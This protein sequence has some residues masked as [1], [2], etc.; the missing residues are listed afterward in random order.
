VGGN[1]AAAN[2]L[3][4][5]EKGLQM[6]LHQ[7]LVYPVAN[8]GFDTPSYQENAKAKP[9]SKDGMQWF[10]EKYLANPQ[11]GQDPL[12][13]LIDI[14]NLKGLPPAT[15]ITAQIDPLRSEGKRYAD[16][17]QQAGVPV[18]YKNYDGVTHEFFGMGAVVD[19]AKEAV[20]QAAKGLK[21]SF[22][23]AEATGRAAPQ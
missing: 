22:E 5:R 23:R 18:D 14:K 2:T 12:I 19:K 3:L 8:Y 7:V 9:L 10:F 16:L 6:P 13:S 15:I 17:L 4:A 11:Q 1:M 20:Q 21:G